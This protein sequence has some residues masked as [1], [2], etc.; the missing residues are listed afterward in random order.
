MCDVEPFYISCGCNRTPHCVDWASSGVLCFGACHSVAIYHPEG[1]SQGHGTISHTL[2]KHT[3]RVNCVKWIQKSNLQASDER[4]ISGSVDKTAIVWKKQKNNQYIPVSVLDFHSGSI[5]VVNGIELTN[6]KETYVVTGSTDSQVMIWKDSGT[7]EFTPLQS[8][9][10]GSGFVLDISL[11]CLPSV[12]VPLFACGCDDHKIHLYTLQDDFKIFQF[13]SKV[14]SLQGHED[15]VRAVNFCVED[16]G[17][18]ML[19]SAGQDYLIRI[20][21]LSRR[22]AGV[23]DVIKS[24]QQLSI[25]EEIKMREN[26]FSFTCKGK[27]HMFAVSLESVLSGHENWIYSIRWQP[28]VVMETSN[29]QPMRLLSAS[30]DKTMIIWSPDQDSGVWIE[31]MRVG[32]VGGNT[33]G[34]YGGM[35]APDGKSIIAHGYQG[36]FHQWSHD[37][38]SNQ[39]RPV[40]TGS[41]HFDEVEDLGWD[42][43]GGQFVVSVSKDQTTRLHAP[44]TY[45]QGQEIWYEI[46]RPQVHGYDLQCLA[47]INRYKFASGADEKVIRA[48][49]A[50][51]NFIENFCSLCGKDLKSE[52]Q[53]EEAQNRPEGASVPALGLSNKAVFSGE[54]ISDNRELQPHPNDQYPEV[55]FT[56]MTLTEPPTE[57]QLLQNT[58]WP[59][60]QK[61]YGHGYEIFSLASD[62]QGKILVSACK[63]AKAEFAGLILW[64]TVSWTQLST[65]SGHTLTVTQMA[66]SH[67]GNFL[68]SVS[69][70]RTWMVY[71]KK[72]SDQPES[73][74]LFSKLIGTD[75]KSAVHARI[76]WSCA[77]SPDDKHFFTASRDKKIIVW[78]NPGLCDDLASALQ[79]VD[80]V[81]LPDSVT[82]IDVSNH[83]LPDNRHLLA[84]GL[85]NGRISLY[86]WKPTVDKSSGFQLVAELDQS[87]SHHLTVKRIRFSPQLKNNKIQELASCSLDHCVKLYRTDLSKL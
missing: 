31:Q 73:D 55:Y 63:A 56:P 74:P 58:L 17:D 39:W 72:T 25:D 41:G 43:G 23:D 40:V 9:N 76:I 37:E 85:D 20:W 8:L 66:F 1:Y 71:K 19:A 51:R 18:I 62:P 28:P 32:E 59:E 65:L 22:Q 82:A 49:E 61:L 10:F 14:M 2:I 7:D 57:E 35:F 75:K 48:F 68:L 27:K 54:R 11:V 4:F 16:S 80:S 46:A 77:W 87:Q 52:L 78:Q 5:T 53:K 30:M 36:A 45:K 38:V 6:Q 86:T 24:V 47:M 26:T 15:W 60:T 70:D 12:E 29:H 69:R 50:P 67:N 3:G 81:T 84:A 21:R 44:T 42:T 34:L 83:L 64:D 79:P 33:L 13:F